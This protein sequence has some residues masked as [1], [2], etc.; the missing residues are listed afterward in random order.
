MNLIY[1]N[2]TIE[3]DLDV[4]VPYIDLD[5]VFLELGIVWEISA[6]L[7]MMLLVNKTLQFW[8]PRNVRRY[9]EEKVIRNLQESLESSE[10]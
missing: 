7:T 1:W 4:L 6:I 2:K 8:M 10:R 5:T 3:V 9:F